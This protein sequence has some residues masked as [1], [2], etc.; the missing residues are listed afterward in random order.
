MPTIVNRC[1][2]LAPLCAIWL[3]I[4]AWAQP[5]RLTAPL[6]KGQVLR[7]DISASLAVSASA[8]PEASETLRQHATLRLTVSEVDGDGDTTLRGVFE[9]LDATWKP[10][11]AEEQTFAWK[12]GQELAEDAPPLA[13][14]YG[15]LGA[16]PI[17]VTVSRAGTIKSV[18]GPDK[19]LESGAA[20][21]LPHPERALGVLAY[22]SL[23]QTLG[24]LFALD[25]P[26]KD[27][28][29]GDSWTT[30]AKLPAL[31][32]A[33]VKVSTE[34]TLKELNGS[35][36]LVE[37]KITQTW[38]AAPGKANSTDPAG[39]PADQKGSAEERWDTAAGRLESR[40]QD[41]AA[42]WKL[43]LRTTPPIE[44]SRTLTSHVELKRLE[45]GPDR[46]PAASP[47]HEKP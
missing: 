11:D 16:T 28:K 40:T 46:A 3:A 31:G 17:E 23:P 33:T 32:G 24:P 30:T 41:L 45:P 2:R 43:S 4:P 29:P 27:R 35:R 6:E 14:A 19:A 42:T 22:H 34:R 1:R 15:A 37:A 44:S 20:A 36:A 25:E 12:E 13:K 39:T 9:S 47:P 18:D 7:Y 26:G 10:A 21:K 5:V 38:Q 8:K